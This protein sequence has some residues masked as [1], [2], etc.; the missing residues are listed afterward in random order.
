[1][2]KVEGLLR[3]KKKIRGDFLSEDLMEKVEDTLIF[4]FSVNCGRSAM[5]ERI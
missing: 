3:C 2:E 1:M 5:I 4:G